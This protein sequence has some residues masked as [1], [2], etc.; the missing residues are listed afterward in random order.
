MSTSAIA[1]A[2]LGSA[3][4]SNQF[5]DLGNVNDIEDEGRKGQESG[6]L[7]KD[8]LEHQVILRNE[9]CSNAEREGFVKPESIKHSELGW[10]VNT[11]R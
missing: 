1:I 11:R 10:I 8:I 4:L 2:W 9:Q 3:G 7:W 6:R 5:S